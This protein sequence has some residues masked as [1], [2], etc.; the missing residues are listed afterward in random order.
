MA[1]L[2]FIHI[3]SLATN[4]EWLVFQLDIK[5]AFLYGNLYKKVYMK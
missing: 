1:R 3:Y 4:L 2:N 5:N